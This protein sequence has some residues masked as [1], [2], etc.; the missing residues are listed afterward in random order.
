MDSGCGWLVRG[1]RREQAPFL[2]TVV[3]VVVFGICWAPF[4]IDRLMWSLVS[5]WTEGLHLAFQYKEGQG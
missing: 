5:H 1:E 2:P 4:H 3:L